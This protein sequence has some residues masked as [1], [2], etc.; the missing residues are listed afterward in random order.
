MYV[1]VTAGSI[2]G[3]SRLTVAK[4]ESSNSTMTESVTLEF[5]KNSVK[6]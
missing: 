2:Q 6:R 5:D 4:V 3:K 1:T